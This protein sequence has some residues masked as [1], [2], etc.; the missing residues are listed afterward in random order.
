MYAPTQD[1]TLPSRGLISR[2]STASALAGTH[3]EGVRDVLREMEKKQDPRD[4]ERTMD[5]LHVDFSEGHMQ[6]FWLTPN[7]RA[8]ET[9]GVTDTGASQL[10]SEVLP[11]HFFTGLKELARMDE[12]GAKLATFAWS[13]FAR[14]HNS[15]PRMVRS[16]NRPVGGDVQRVIRSCHSVSYAPYSNLNFVEDLLE[17]GG[18]YVNMP[19]LDWRVGDRG[20]RLRFAGCERS[21]IEVNKPTPMLEAWNSEVGLRKVVLR[22]GIWEWSCTN[23]MGHWDERVDFSWIHRG[24]MRRIQNGVK[25]AFQNLLTTAHGI[26]GVYEEALNISIDNAFEW[27][28]QEL[29]AAKQPERIVK[30]AQAALGHPTTTPGGMLASAVDAITLVAQDEKTLWEQADVEKA[31]SRILSRGR[32]VA[33]R[34]NGHIPVA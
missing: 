22:G 6:A 7:G 15:V 2:H 31:A 29:V 16:V 19:I 33:L 23:G 27:L 3:L 32:G 34:N 1:L 24:D 8:A 26:V 4:Y 9:L 21:E 20:M 13:K 5:Q 12:Q 30:A 28:A 10:A 17:S 14:A 11:G 18:D 25:D